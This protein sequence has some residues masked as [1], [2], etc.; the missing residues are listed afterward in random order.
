MP[1]GF[2]A[3]WRAARFVVPVVLLAVAMGTF[4]IVQHDLS[5]KKHAARSH[6]SAA[7][8]RTQRRYRSKRFYVVQ[9]GDSLTLIAARSG[10][11]VGEIETLNPRVDPN[12]LRPGQRLRLRR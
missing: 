1:E 6:G 10:V 11:A 7:P 12:S 4:L 2:E 8:S 9:S 3:R 5:S